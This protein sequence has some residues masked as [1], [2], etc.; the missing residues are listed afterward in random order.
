MSERLEL[1]GIRDAAMQPPAGSAAGYEQM[2]L[3]QFQQAAQ[4]E[5]NLRRAAVRAATQRALDRSGWYNVGQMLIPQDAGEL[6]LSAAM[7][8]GLG[9]GMRAAL[10]A[11]GGMTTAPAEAEGG[12]LPRSWFESLLRSRIPAARQEGERALDALTRAERG[13]NIDAMRWAKPDEQ[14]TMFRALA[15][16]T[17]QHGWLP[18]GNNRWM[19]MADPQRPVDSTN[20]NATVDRVRQTGRGETS[21]TE[22]LVYDPVYFEAA[23][24]AL[25]LGTRG[26]FTRF[27]PNMEGG[28]YSPGGDIVLGTRPL[29]ELTPYDVLRHEMQ[30]STIDRAGVSYGGNNVEDAWQYNPSL[31]NEYLYEMFDNPQNAAN[32]MYLADPGEWLARL[33]ERTNRPGAQIGDANV[34]FDPNVTWPDFRIR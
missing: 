17:W 30:H 14:N 23:D 6:A 31:R 15:P 11:L 21:L 2:L 18:F 20:F 33:A 26:R 19:G 25:N 3:G 4:D 24:R 16:E 1:S 32:Q 13:V 27:D 10:A 28:Y 12:M 5:E 22:N 29:D 9:R 7:G 8:P 34:L